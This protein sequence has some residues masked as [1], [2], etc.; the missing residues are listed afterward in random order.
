M[1]RVIQESAA[2]RNFPENGKG[3]KIQALDRQE[4]RLKLLQSEH[5]IFSIST[6]S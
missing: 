4:G 5:G 3:P 1:K 2:F 6:S